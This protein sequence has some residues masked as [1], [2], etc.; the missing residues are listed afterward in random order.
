M[1][2]RTTTRVS[3]T[4]L[5]GT[6]VTDA[7]GAVCGRLKDIAVATGADAGKVAGLVLK[8][9]AGLALVPSQEVRE[10]AAGTLQVLSTSA[11]TPLN[12]EQGTY[13]YLQQD[14]VD[15][16]IIDIHGRKVVRVNDVDLEWMGEGQAHLLRVAEV[17]VGLRGAFRR[18]FK[19][20]LPKTTLDQLARRFKERGIPWQFVD[21]IE[22]DP[23][24]R[25]KLR[26]EYERL[27]EMHP[28]DLAEILEDLSPAEREAVFTSLDEEVAAETLEEVDPKLQ[29]S[30]LEKLDE[31]KIADIVEEMDPGAAA[32][33]LAELPEDRS[34]AILE[35]MEPEE[36]QEVEE[37]LEFDE[38][39]AAGAMTTD[40]VYLGTD[41]VVSQVGP[42]LRS[43]DGDVEAVT[44]IY[45]LDEKRVVR[46][47][48]PLARLIVAQPD[49]KLTV[50]ADA[51][52]LSCPADMRQ[53]DLAEMFDKYNLHALPVVDKAGRM[54]GV[55]QAD[56]VISFLREKL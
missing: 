53:L 54:V 20:V 44:E 2:H 24:R 10:T 11:I 7:Q 5:L 55:V 48:V 39:S 28:S 21:V 37:L 17:E 14:L 34:D 31:E 49:T 15:R 19:G 56:H 9:R 50:L 45:L 42:A 36:R 12:G 8:T 27:A 32:D 52:V 40:F 25:V 3:L 23:A 41:A 16:Q 46:G 18:V 29:V 38:N 4:A 13:I 47:A 51:R 1:N 43:Y 22:V 26:I 6:P 33:L 30:L 35:E